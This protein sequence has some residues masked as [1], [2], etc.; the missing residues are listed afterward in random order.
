M[1]GLLAGATPELRQ[2]L[3]DQ[4][5]AGAI[6]SL[7]Q[8]LLPVIQYNLDAISTIALTP[9]QCAQTGPLRLSRDA[10]ERARDAALGCLQSLR[11]PPGN[12][13][14][15]DACLASV[16][17]TAQRELDALQPSINA[18]LQ[19]QGGNSN[20]NNAANIDTTQNQNVQT[21]NS[22]LK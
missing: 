18:C 9:N 8:T 21:I 22:N 5:L 11:T 16:Y 15:Y 19:T 17:P 4:S 10:I 1:N 6:A 20:L 13:E 14:A 12:T 7:R 2:L 3:N